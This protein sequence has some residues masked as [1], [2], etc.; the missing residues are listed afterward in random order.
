ME[1][2]ASNYEDGMNQVN[3]HSGRGITI[4]K[5][6]TGV[7]EKPK[8]IDPVKEWERV[9]K[10]WKGDVAAWERYSGFKLPKTEE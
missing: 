2:S 5:L 4:G 8:K 3:I 9:K 10:V 7:P 6:V 1:K